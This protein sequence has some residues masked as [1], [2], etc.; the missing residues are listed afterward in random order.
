MPTF[1][2]DQLLPT[3]PTIYYIRHDLRRLKLETNE[4][5]ADI[6][7]VLLWQKYNMKSTKF[8]KI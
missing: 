3:N 6:G 7:T 2:E 1:R 5:F 8:G 4:E